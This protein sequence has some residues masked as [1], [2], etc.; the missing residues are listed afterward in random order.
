MDK[1][2]ILYISIEGNTRSFLKRLQAFA[3]QQ[4][5]INSRDLEIN[6]K[7]ITDQTLPEAEEK[8]FFAFV[9]TYL[10]GG[11]GFDSGFTE[12]M[13]NALGE[14]IDSHDN[15]KKCLGIVGSGNKNF[16]EQYC[17]TARMYSKKFNTP[18]LAD[19]ELR[20]TDEDIDTIYSI[21]QKRWK[22]SQNN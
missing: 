18:F 19:Y 13:T 15:Y 4:H 10:D 21:L 12:L 5:S 20:G 11:N 9:P 14:Y 16:N 6:L 8:N 22:D 2:N 17:L 7:E 1:I 3:K